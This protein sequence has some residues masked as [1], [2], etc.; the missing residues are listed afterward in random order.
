VT[1]IVITAEVLGG[2]AV[3]AAAVLTACAREWLH[4][5]VAVTVKPIPSSKRKSHPHSDDVQPPADPESA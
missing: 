2:L 3:L 4:I 5:A 1:P